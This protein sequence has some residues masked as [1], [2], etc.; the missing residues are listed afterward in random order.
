[1]NRSELN[2]IPAN[3]PFVNDAQ[4]GGTGFYALIFFIFI[5]ITRIQ[6][7]IIPLRVIRPGAL[8]ISLLLL[9]F[10]F[11]QARV[12]HS[13]YDYQPIRYVL[14]F[15]ALGMISACFSLWP[16][17]SIDFMLTEFGLLL[18]FMLTV[19][20]VSGNFRDMVR[21]VWAMSLSLAVLAMAS[22]LLTK[23]EGVGEYVVDGSLLVR[24]GGRAMAGGT[25]DPNDIS[26]MIVSFMPLTYFLFRNEQGAR[27]VAA[28]FLLLGSF[29][30]VLATVSRSGFIGFVVIAAMI[31]IR[32]RTGIVKSAL[33]LAVIVVAINFFAPGN[34][35]DRMSTILDPKEDYNYSSGGGRLEIWKRG[36]EI[37]KD[38][39][40]LGAG[41]AVFAIAEGREHSDVGGKWS[42]AHNSLIQ[43]GGEL[44]VMGL[45]LYVMILVSCLKA[46]YRLRRELPEDYPH[47]WLLNGL[48]IG[49]YG[50]MAAGFFLSQAY[51]IMLFLLVGLTIVM[52]NAAET[53]GVVTSSPP[54]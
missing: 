41:P 52:V 3:T 37:I 19:V 32:Q 6:E 44:G 16:S 23:G 54:V 20:K 53:E 33:A 39:P 30:G 12:K 34:F 45:V 35:W 29:V 47:R 22:V 24:Q 28:F 38:S 4:G 42:T 51:S 31:L 9:V 18:V 43:V 27:K 49:F 15:S 36:F 25:Y 40:F 5:I 10:L 14:Y 50:Y 48:E 46:I 7:Y 17:R 1:M 2:V 21:I 11:V 26:F 8:S 13:P